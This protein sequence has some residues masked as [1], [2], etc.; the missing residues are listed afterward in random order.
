MD[1]DQIIATTRRMTAA[2]AM[3]VRD[4]PFFGHLSMGLRLA[5]A[6]CGTACTDGERLIFDPAFA[7]ELKTDRE[8]QF[9]VLHEVLHCVLE[10]C[11]R[12]GARDAELYNTA[13]DIVV[14]S[15][16][17]EMWGM[18]VFQVAGQDVMH[19]AP[20]GSEGRLYNAEELYEMLLKPGGSPGN[21]PGGRKSG[22]RGGSA[23]PPSAPGISGGRLD[24]HDI[25]QA[26]RDTAR[27]RDHWNQKIIKAA[28]DSGGLG[29]ISPSLRV[30]AEKLI[31]RSKVDWRQMLHDFIQHDTYDYSFLPPDRRF[32]DGDLYLP[33]YNIDY[34]QGSVS[35]IWVCVDA[36]GSISDEQL[37][38]FVLEVCDAMRQAGLTGSVSFFDTNITSPRPFTTE[39][40][41]RTA[42]PVGGGGTSFHVIFRY[43]KEH[44]Y[45]DLPRAILIFTDGFV[46]DW[47]EETAALGVPVLWLICEDGNT[48]VPWGLTAQM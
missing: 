22:S 16:I 11:T 37:T 27:I 35:D 8:M 7:R 45:P 40:E 23:M 31:H 33:A 41:F 3:L 5:C 34:D 1:Q 30:L 15:T 28:G 38:K 48:A 9:V 17:L 20:D 14:N 32:S 25:W 19:L 42:V 39:A 47:P 29:D 36:S 46:F 12:G 44:L 21:F 6:P 26:I 18:T 10:H 13:C 43:L 24:R 4:N 2:R